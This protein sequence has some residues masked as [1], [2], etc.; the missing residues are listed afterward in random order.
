M[1]W[2]ETGHKFRRAV[3]LQVAADRAEPNRIRLLTSFRW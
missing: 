2:I 1:D 3:A